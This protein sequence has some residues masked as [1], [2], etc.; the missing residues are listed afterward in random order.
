MLFIELIE[1]YGNNFTVAYVDIFDDEMFHMYLRVYPTRDQNLFIC[2]I[3]IDTQDTNEHIV[4]SDKSM[5]IPLKDL[6]NKVVEDFH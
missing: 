2:N 5:R 6:A 4:M 1:Q 3:R